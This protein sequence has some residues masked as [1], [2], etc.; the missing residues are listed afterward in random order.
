MALSVLAGCAQTTSS[1]SPTSATVQTTVAESSGIDLNK[2][3]EYDVREMTVDNNG[4]K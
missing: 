3:Y 4:E 1:S 2:R